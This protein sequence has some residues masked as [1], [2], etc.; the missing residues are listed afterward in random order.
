MHSQYF[1]KKLSDS[2]IAPPLDLPGVGLAI[3]GTPFT[4]PE[5]V[6]LPQEINANNEFTQVW[7]NGKI[8][9]STIDGDFNAKRRK[10][11]SVKLRLNALV[12]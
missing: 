9:I 6:E 11:E 12:K 4:A 5:G 1:S 2:P 10:E 3:P 7:L 8:S